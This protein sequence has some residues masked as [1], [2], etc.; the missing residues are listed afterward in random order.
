[1][2]HGSGKIVSVGGLAHVAAQLAQQSCLHP[3]QRMRQRLR[4]PIE[5]LKVLQAEAH[6]VA[7][8]AEAFFGQR[9]RLNR[10]L[11]LAREVLLQRPQPQHVRTQGPQHLVQ[12]LVVLA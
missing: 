7:Q 2:G 12:R 1:M 4:L 11:Q 6:G 10:E 3:V 8:L 5:I 9:K